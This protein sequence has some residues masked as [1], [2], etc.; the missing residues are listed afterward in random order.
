MFAQM[1]TSALAW[2]G[3]LI[4]AAV[5]PLIVALY[6]LKLRRQPLEVPSTYLWHRT[7]EDLHVNSLWQRLRHSLL[8]L[9]QLLL[10]ALVM[11]AC[12]RPSWHGTKLVGSRFIFLVDTSASM[13]ATDIS[14]SRLE[15]AKQQ[16]AA[17]IEQMESGDAAMIVSFSD[18]PRVEQE[19]TDN[20]RLLR[21]R[22]A[23]IKP[24]HRTSNLDEALRVAAGLA[25]PA[26][27]RE[28]ESNV[29][30]VADALPATLYIFSD[31]NVPPVSDF[32][33]GN[34]EPK[35]MPIGHRDCDNV[36]IVAFSTERNPQRPDRIQ[37]FGRLEH[38]FLKQDSEQD[39]KPFDVGVD[40][41]LDDNLIDSQNITMTEGG[42][43][44]LEFD[45]E[46]IESGTLRLEINQKDHLA[47][48]NVAFT[49]INQPRPAK[50]LLVS[51][52]NDA[53]VMALGT[54]RSLTL[55]DVSLAD[56]EILGQSSYQK[57]ASTNAY[58][59]IIYDQCAPEQMPQCNTLFIGRLP[60]Q[61]KWQSE[62]AQS[63]PQIVD[64][65]RAHPLM[66]FVELGNVR[67]AEA[68]P[69][70]PPSG[71]TVLI[72]TDAGPI[73]AIAPR[74]G[75]EDA[76]LGFEIVDT[77]AGEANTDWPIRLSFPLFIDN[78]L[79]Y[80]GGVIGRGPARGTVQPGQSIT[81]QANPASGRVRVE[82]PWGE[83]FGVARDPLGQITFSDTHQIGVYQV[84]ESS[85][86]K[87][88]ERFTVNLFDGAESN[89]RPQAELEIG[90][91]VVAAQARWEPTRREGWKY[92]LIGALGVLLFE[93]YIFNRRV[94]L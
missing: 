29:A 89:I 44:G 35:F 24:T 33:L 51:P 5:P 79:G 30:S 23:A 13:T 8:L 7:I 4:L 20:R 1:F 21:R 65:D 80:L 61:K 49:T 83:T 36:G 10:I 2:W 6:F 90:H 70:D 52:G 93:W 69:L 17:L 63:V 18:T 64:T 87:V 77:P 88:A 53:L 78:V 25:N 81:L 28:R 34:L 84:R 43:S 42:T 45:L 26:D 16:V 91:S 85:T 3:W 67:I 31:G 57:S 46:E 74:E 9:L 32:S 50:V 48:D 92:L 71:S 22:L 41:Y 40:I 59:L 47:V 68:T 58:D 54:E 11:L 66:Q 55:A 60:P 39:S 72:D 37:A 12:L 19:F 14:P 62:E 94:Y 82:S 15:N 56:P 75:Y 27:S 76:V 73:F 38:Y 86:G